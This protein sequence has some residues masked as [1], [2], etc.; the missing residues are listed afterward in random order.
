MTAQSRD[1]WVALD[2]ELESWGDA[3]LTASLW[4]RD[5]DAVAPSAELDRLLSLAGGGIPMAL[6]VIPAGA[7]DGLPRRLRAEHTISVLQHGYSHANHRPPGARA[8]EFGGDRPHSEEVRDLEH[9]AERLRLLFGGRFLPAFV[10]PWNR[11]DG[12]LAPALGAL[13]FTGLSGFGPR[14]A[15]TR[16]G[17]VL[18]NTHVDPIAWRHGRGFIGEDAAIGRLVG[19]LADRRNGRV[20]RDEPTGLLTHHRVHPPELWG[21]L[22]RL[23]G[24]LRHP[25]VRWQAASALFAPHSVTADPVPDGESR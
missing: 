3:G 13:G 16:D 7:E 15:A 19:H 2:A 11:I 5:D 25:A 22:E 12:R 8:S 21:F 23:A 1:P 17:L 10:P 14:D 4:W 18:V 6:A 24:R 20:D 9:G